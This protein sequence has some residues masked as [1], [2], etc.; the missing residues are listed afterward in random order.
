MRHHRNRRNPN[1]VRGIVTGTNGQASNGTVQVKVL[2]T[3]NGRF[4]NRGQ[5]AANANAANANANAANANANAAN[6]NANAAN[7]N[8]KRKTANVR[9]FQ[10][11]NST[12]YQIV[13]SQGIYRNGSFKK[14]Q[15][16]EP[17]LVLVGNRK[18][19]AA[20]FAQAIDMFPKNKKA[21]AAAPAVAAQ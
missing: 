15:P 2:A 16:G 8:A 11:N 1:I 18:G 7:A 14:L 13:S 5:N 4:R 12:R 9:T 19:G 10:V 6:A 17:V 21:L 20:N 3:S